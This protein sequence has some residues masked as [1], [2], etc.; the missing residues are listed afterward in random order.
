MAFRQHQFQQTAQRQDKSAVMLLFITNQ[1]K[2]LI[3]ML[4]EDGIIIAFM[5]IIL[6]IPFNPFYI[7]NH[8]YKIYANISSGYNVPSLYQLYSEY[9]NK[10]LK[11][12]VTTSYE[13]G[14]QFT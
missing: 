3:L 9:G 14:T 12:E 2:D 13:V 1:Q 11:P 5:E 8:H 7:I 10:N 6:R 4:A